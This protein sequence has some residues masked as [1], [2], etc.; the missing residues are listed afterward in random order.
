MMVIEIERLS[1]NN[2]KLRFRLK[3]IEDRGLDRN[4]YEH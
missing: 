2:E 4:S 1:Y 3:D